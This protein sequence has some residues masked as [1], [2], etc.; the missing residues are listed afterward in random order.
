MENTHLKFPQG[1]KWYF[2]LFMQS[3]QQSKNTQKIQFATKMKKTK[4][5]YS[6]ETGKKA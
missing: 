3:D 5:F 1:P 2:K 4:N 6:E